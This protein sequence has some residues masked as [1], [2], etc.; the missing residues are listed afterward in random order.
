MFL[1]PEN[2]EAYRIHVPDGVLP[3]LPSLG[4]QTVTSDGRVHVE[5]GSSPRLESVDTARY[6]RSTTYLPHQDPAVRDLLARVDSSADTAAGRAEALRSFVASYLV[7]KNLDTV[8]A[9]ASEV[10][11]TR[12]G[13]CTEHSVLLAALLRAAEIPSRVVSG[14]IYV[15]RFAGKS[16][17]FSYHMW[18]QALVD[19]RWIDLDS[20]L[21]A[22]FDAGHIALAATA[23]DDGESALREMTGIVPLM[24]RARIEVVEVEYAD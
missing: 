19:N 16:E 15:E 10:A 6:L 7:E 9:T 4:A 12:S 20:T 3:E 18:T 22:R 8:L 24:G 11:L 5:L 17:I 23:L 21:P 1:L 13:D 14:L 2:R